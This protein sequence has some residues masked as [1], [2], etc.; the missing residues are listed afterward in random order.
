MLVIRLLWTVESCA[1]RLTPGSS[2]T[3]RGHPNV[4]FR[5]VTMDPTLFSKHRQI[6]PVGVFAFIL[7]AVYA[8]LLWVHL[9]GISVLYCRV[10]EQSSG[11]VAAPLGRSE[12]GSQL[13]KNPARNGGSPLFPSSLKNVLHPSPSMSPPSRS[14]AQRIGSQQGHLPPQYVA[15]RREHHG[16]KEGGECRTVQTSDL[17]GSCSRRAYYLVMICYYESGS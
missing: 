8:P 4:F 13:L 14:A 1:V 6:L 12:V 16:E 17:P 9:S 11:S 7:H 15:R 2:R 5:L 10:P 3:S